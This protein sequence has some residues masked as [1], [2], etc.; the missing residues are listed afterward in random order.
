MGIH[1]DKSQQERDWVLN[2]KPGTPVDPV[3][4]V[5][6]NFNKI[7]SLI[8]PSRV[9]IWKSS[10]THCY[11]CC[12]QRSRSVSSLNSL[13]LYFKKKVHLLSLTLLLLSEFLP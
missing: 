8:F 12:L 9:Q 3:S 13:L 7:M 4:K 10:D 11:R 2:G 1:G 5:L 6:Y